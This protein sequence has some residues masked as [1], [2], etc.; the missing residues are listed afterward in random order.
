MLDKLSEEY[1][2]LWRSPNGEWVLLRSPDS[3][4]GYSI[5]NRGGHVLLIEDDAIS[6]AVCSKMLQAGCE[7][8]DDVP[9]TVA[10]ARPSNP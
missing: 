5:F 6:D 8:L 9:A 2:H 3:T 4:G 1:G 10:I 7:V